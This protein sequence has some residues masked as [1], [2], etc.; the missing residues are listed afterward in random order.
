[1]TPVALSWV[2]NHLNKWSNKYYV[3]SERYESPSTARRTPGTRLGKRPSFPWLQTLEKRGSTFPDCF[4]I[5]SGYYVAQFVWNS[6]V[7]E[8]LFHLW[9]HI[10]AALF[11]VVTLLD[12]LVWPHKVVSPDWGLTTDPRALALWDTE[13]SRASSKLFIFSA[14]IPV[15]TEKTH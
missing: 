2:E 9:I 7:N 13:E 1:M 15:L 5:P 10:E 4:P 12:L 11:Y 6:A 3:S 8:I 14:I